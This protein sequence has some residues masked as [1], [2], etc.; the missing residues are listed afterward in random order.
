V[1]VQVTDQAGAT[2]PTPARR[3]WFVEEA[4]E[5]MGVT[6]DHVYELLRQKKL[7]G[8]RAGKRWLI[9]H[10]DLDEYMARAAAGEL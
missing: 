8:W 2:L 3:T 6:G 7:R 9:R 1:A 5:I 10:E 4:A